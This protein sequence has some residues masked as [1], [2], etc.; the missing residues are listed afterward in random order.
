M[1]D[2][3]KFQLSKFIDPKREYQIVIR[4]ESAEGMRDALEAMKP[5]VEGI[6]NRMAA[7]PD[8]R[9]FVPIAQTPTYGSHCDIHDVEMQQKEWQ[10][11]TFWSHRTEDGQYWCNG[12][13]LTPVK[14]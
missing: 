2:Y 8:T 7:K 5:F 3:P 13:K 10:G 6:K 11:K 9:T 4:T 14:K 1:A 12:K